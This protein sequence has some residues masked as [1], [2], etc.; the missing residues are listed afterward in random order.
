MIRIWLR[1]KYKFIQ[2]SI[3]KLPRYDEFKW[4]WYGCREKIA[5][6]SAGK[7]EPRKKSNGRRVLGVTKDWL[8]KYR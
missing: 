3:I 1:G 6:V 2:I 4:N 5:A 7:Y 8:L